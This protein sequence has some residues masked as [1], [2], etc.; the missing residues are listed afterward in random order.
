[1]ML[2][3]ENGKETVK[4]IPIKINQ[5]HNSVANHTQ[6]HKQCIDYL[7]IKIIFRYYDFFYFSFLVF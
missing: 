2:G 6:K 4:I 1:M 5:V 3:A 7:V